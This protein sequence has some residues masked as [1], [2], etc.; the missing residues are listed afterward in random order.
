MMSTRLLGLV[1]VASLAACGKPPVAPARPPVPVETSVAEI[2]DVPLRLSAVGTTA[3]AELVTVRPQVTAMLAKVLFSEGDTVAAGTPLFQLDDR[4]STTAVALAQA[5]AERA[6]AL[7]A[8][9]EA[10]ALRNADLERQGLASAQQNDQVRSAL[11]AGKAALAAANAAQVRARLDLSWCTVTAPIAGRTGAVGI[12]SGNLVSA[13]Q[14]ALVVI[15]RM[16][17]MR[18]TFTLP[19]NV[20][21]QIRAAQATAPLAVSVRVDGDDT[22]E[23]GIL[24]LID[25]QVDAATA[26]I[27]LRASCPNLADRLWPG[28]QCRVTLTLGTEVAVVTVPERAVQTGQRGSLVWVVGNGNMVEPRQ[29]TIARN[30]DGLAVIAAGLAGGETVVVDG[31]LRLSKGAIVTTAADKPSAQ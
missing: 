2:R 16:Q 8:L 13:G 3:A 6:R 7:L 29:V 12:T 5:E 14:T 21:G 9:A 24:D 15:A 23:G 18:V 27:R 22:V 20:L 11:D 1:L 30:S 10:A 31:Q 25:N 4:A 19:A 28:Q 26:S 17:P